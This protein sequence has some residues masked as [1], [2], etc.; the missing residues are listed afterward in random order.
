MLKNGPLDNAILASVAFI[1][2]FI[3]AATAAADNNDEENATCTVKIYQNRIC[4]KM[5]TVP[6]NFG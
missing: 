4:F 5:K 1:A 3:A 6:L 2:A